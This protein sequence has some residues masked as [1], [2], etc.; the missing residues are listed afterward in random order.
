MGSIEVDCPGYG[1]LLFAAD[2]L[3][4][5]TDFDLRS[6]SGGLRPDYLLFF[7]SRGISG[8]F[9]GSLIERLTDAIS[10]RGNSFLSVCRP[11]ELTTW[12]TLVNFIM[13]NDLNP[14]RIVTNMGFVDFTPKKRSIL[15]D[16][17]RQV[18]FHVGRGV[19]QSRQVEYAT[20]SRGEEIPLY[21][22]TYEE[23]FRRQIELAVARQPTLVLNSPLVDPRIRIER[24]RPAAFFAALAE[25]NAFN[26]SIRGAEVIDLP[27]FDEALTYDAVHYTSRGNE[28]IFA[29]IEGRL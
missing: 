12:A 3:H 5:G 26:R 23:P 18:D 8:G 20:S 1:P 4:A 21:A 17:I 6:N 2:R 28:L 15:E 22:M 14:G 25:S 27:V 13:L 29:T 11:L 19:A 7:D 10:D 24:A 9:A 16:A